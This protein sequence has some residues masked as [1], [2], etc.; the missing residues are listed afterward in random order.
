MQRLP[1]SIDL[2]IT[3]TRFT[4]LA[5]RAETTCRNGNKEFCRRYRSII[6][7]FVLTHPTTHMPS[8]AGFLQADAR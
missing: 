8:F 3:C 2:I 6:K 1:S 4:I 7:S 5:D